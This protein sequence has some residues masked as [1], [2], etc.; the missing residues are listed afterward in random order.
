M[1]NIH[2]IKI[3]NGNPVVVRDSRPENIH[4]Q[5][6]KVSSLPIILRE[7]R[8]NHETVI[9]EDLNGIN[10]DHPQFE[11]YQSL[12]KPEKYWIDQGARWVDDVMDAVIAGF[13]RVVV[14]TTHIRNL[15]ELEDAAGLTPNLMLDIINKKGKIE[16]K[17]ARL[18]KMSIER[19]VSMLMELEFA[20][21]I[22]TDV[23]NMDEQRPALAVDRTPPI[24]SFTIHLRGEP[25]HS[26]VGRHF[27][28]ISGSVIPFQHAKGMDQYA[29]VM[30]PPSSRD[31]YK[32]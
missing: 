16:S 12:E 25:S 29:E 7:F 30:K 5:D 9:I 14:R 27:D 26:G 32:E 3:W 8:K 28:L 10:D 2:S 13:G 4:D 21:A 22:I 15:E 23:S 20:G 6:G 11:L 24:D 1:P 19:F 31:L 18:S 17:D